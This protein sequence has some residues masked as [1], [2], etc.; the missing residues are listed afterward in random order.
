MAR[1][2]SHLAP[3]SP[4]HAPL[5]RHDQPPVPTAPPSSTAPADGDRAVPSPA[6][7]DPGSERPCHLPMAWA[8][9]SGLDHPGA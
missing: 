2:P 5:A 9:R 3:H 6:A 4:P 8:A 1:L 7:P